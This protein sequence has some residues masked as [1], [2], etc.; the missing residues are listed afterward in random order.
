MMINWPRL[1]LGTFLC[2]SSMFYGSSFFTYMY[3]S[4]IL[5]S[6]HQT[7]HAYIPNQYNDL[8]WCKAVGKVQGEDHFLNIFT[9]PLVPQA[10]SWI[11]ST[12]S[13]L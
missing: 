13:Y 8:E 12:C 3:V 2:G 11:L 9:Y 6:Q 10:T 1:L 4:S 5:I 7:V